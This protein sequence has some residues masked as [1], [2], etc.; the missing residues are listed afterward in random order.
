MFIM[1][2]KPM[3]PMN[4]WNEDAMMKKIYF[5]ELYKIFLFHSK[6]TFFLEEQQEEDVE[7]DDEKILS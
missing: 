1:V 4:E 3:N 7:E 2:T 5:K 6:N